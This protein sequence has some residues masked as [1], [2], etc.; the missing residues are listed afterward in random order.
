MNQ[1]ASC[2]LETQTLKPLMR[3]CYMD[4]IFYI[5]THSEFMRGLSS[6]DSNI[7][8]TYEYSN[9]RVPFLDLQ[10]DIG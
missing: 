3:L 1:L 9:K 8:F 5:W 4:D 6:F 2:F 7:R 10:V